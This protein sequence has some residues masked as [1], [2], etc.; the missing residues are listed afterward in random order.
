MDGIGGAAFALRHLGQGH[1]GVQVVGHQEPV[2]DAQ[3]RPPRLHHLQVL[4]RL[5]LLHMNMRMNMRVKL[6]GKKSGQMGG[7]TRV[8]PGV[9]AHSRLCHNLRGSLKTPFQAT[10]VWVDPLTLETLR[11]VSARRQSK[12]SAPVEPISYWRR[13]LQNQ[14]IETS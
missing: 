4:H 10:G 9:L 13:L 1:T 6:G 8:R 2:H 14:T 7:S 3:Q 5:A 11:R 12:L